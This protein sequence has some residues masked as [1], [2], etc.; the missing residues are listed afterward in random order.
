MSPWVLLV[1]GSR[2]LRML[3]RATGAMYPGL[4][5]RSLA[6]VASGEVPESVIAQGGV[7]RE[8]GCCCD[9]ERQRAPVEGGAPQSGPADVAGQVICRIVGEQGRDVDRRIR[10]GRIVRVDQPGNRRTQQDVVRPE[11]PVDDAVRR[12]GLRGEHLIDTRE[13]GRAVGPLARDA[14]DDAPPLITA[15][16]LACGTELGAQRGSRLRARAPTPRGRHRG[17][18][19]GGATGSSA[20]PLAARRGRR[21]GTRRACSSCGSA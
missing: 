17:W 9:L 12:I 5:A 3:L 8:F 7:A 15:A 11:V 4:S 19:G 2:P 18:S 10:P 14:S 13:G 16:P 21:P 6:L 1:R 20:T